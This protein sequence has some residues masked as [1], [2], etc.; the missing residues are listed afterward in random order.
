[1]EHKWKA[2]LNVATAEP[3]NWK[4]AGVKPEKSVTEKPAGGPRKAWNAGSLAGVVA[5]EELQEGKGGD[6]VD[7]SSCWDATRVAQPSLASC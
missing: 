5:V 6:D 7:F 3:V 4:A 2:A 1:M